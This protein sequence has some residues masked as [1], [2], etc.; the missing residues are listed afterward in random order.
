MAIENIKIDK[1]TSNYVIEVKKSNADIE[2]A[3]WQLIYYLKVLKGKG[4]IRKGKIECV[5]KSKASKKVIDIELNEEIEKQLDKYINDIYL[6]IEDDK[7][8]QTINS[9]TCKKCAYYEY[10]YI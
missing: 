5:E 7:V 3:K 10:C 2:A 8:P 6:L 9:N 1:I 4:V